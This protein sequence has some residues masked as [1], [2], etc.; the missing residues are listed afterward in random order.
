MASGRPINPS[1]GK[2]PEFTD[3]HTSKYLKRGFDALMAGNYQEAGSCADL[4][5]KYRPKLA[6]AHFLVGLIA[7]EM[8]DWGIARKAYSTVVEIDKTHAAAWAQ[9]ARALVRT[10]HY[11]RAFETLA[12][13]VKHG[14][15]DP[16]VQDLVGT[17]YDLIGNQDEALNGTKGRAPNPTAQCLL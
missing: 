15:N 7:T 17:V 1:R 16:L 13:A 5:L 9:L 2:A 10:G 4:I 12:E 3:Q 8:S 14:S 6:Q 11:N